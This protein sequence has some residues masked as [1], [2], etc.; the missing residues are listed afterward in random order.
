MDLALRSIEND[1]ASRSLLVEATS[2]D[3]SVIELRSE[4]ERLRN[5]LK[6]NQLLI[7]DLKENESNYLN[8]IRHLKSLLN[9]DLELEPEKV[10]VTD[11]DFY[12]NTEVDPNKTAVEK[13]I[14]FN[15]DLE[16]V[17]L[18][19]EINK[20]TV[21]SV[22]NIRDDDFSSYKEKYLELY[23]TVEN[24]TH[25]AFAE[26]QNEL[27]QQFYEEYEELKKECAR[28]LEIELQNYKVKFYFNSSIVDKYFL[29][30]F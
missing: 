19:N 11:T 22:L 21:N 17:E 8:E 15:I 10:N 7:G 6:E 29:D 16:I 4:M 30:S 14:L 28:K 26:L 9:K 13:E 20:S 23:E 25:P 1:L 12:V 27:N 2:N 5:E 18:N 24:M 3:V